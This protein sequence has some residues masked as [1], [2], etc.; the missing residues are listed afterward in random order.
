ME[1]K[2]RRNKQSKTSMR[3]ETKERM[4]KIRNIEDEYG[5]MVFRAAL[6][7][8]TDVGHN[9]FDDASVEQTINLIKQQ[10]IDCS[11]AG[12][13]IMSADFKCEIVCCAA[14]LAKFSIWT[15]FRYIKEYVVVDN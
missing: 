12:A 9:K 2:L 6:T 13:S 10:E 3:E 4:R 7:H 5:L 1:S 8:L 11:D 14:A 15:L